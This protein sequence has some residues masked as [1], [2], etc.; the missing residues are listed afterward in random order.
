MPIDQNTMRQLVDT[1]MEAQLR[2][3][4][5]ATPAANDGDTVLDAVRVRALTSWWWRPRCAAPI[6]LAQWRAFARRRC[7]F[8]GALAIAAAMPLLLIALLPDLASRWMFF[9]FACATALAAAW[10]WDVGNR[11]LQ[12]IELLSDQLAQRKVPRTPLVW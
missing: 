9:G 2:A 10:Q 12:T 6:T 5:L 8:A 7:R 4:R 1:L 11:E 3:G